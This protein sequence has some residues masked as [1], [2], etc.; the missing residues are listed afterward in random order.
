MKKKLLTLL[1]ISFCLNFYA[2]VKYEKSYFINNEGIKTECFIKNKDKNENPIDFEYKLSADEAQIMKADIKTV[3][4]FKIG[5]VLKYERSAVKIDTSND[6][7]D[8]LGEKR[9]PLLK[10]KNVFL[11]VLVEGEATLYEYRGQGITRYF[12]KTGSL[13]IEALV[14]KRYYVEGTSLTELAVNND[15]QKQLWTNLNCGNKSI[16][17]ALKLKYNRKELVEYFID[18]NRC[19]NNNFVDFSDKFEQGS[20]NFKV[21]AGIASSSLKASNN[22]SPEDVNFGNKV[23]FTFGGEIEYISPFNRNKWSIFL[24]PTYSS[25]NNETQSQ[26]KIHD[27]P[28]DLNTG[29]SQ[30]WKASFSNLDIAVGIRYYMF[31]NDKSKIF[32]TGSYIA[33]KLFN[34]E[35]HDANT[36]GYE[37][38]VKFAGSIAYGV[39]Y[40]FKNKFNVEIKHITQKVLTGYTSWESKYNTTSVVFGYTIFDSKK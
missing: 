30:T 20:V 17:Q 3:K 22:F 6:K 35:F 1:F 25:Y 19:K 2:Q 8:R 28:F 12:Y 7:L 14:Y 23:G 37:L 40:S 15:F 39:G 32:L 26:A 33:S 31:L 4:E 18:F 11:K 21:K 38:D 13:P 27:N 29:T 10:D 34:S 36:S 9:E 24:A 16:D 5:E